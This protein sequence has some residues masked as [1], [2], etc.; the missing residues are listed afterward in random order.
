MVTAGA[1]W[2]AW[3]YI[4]PRVTGDHVFC[5]HINSSR[6]GL[7]AK[8]SLE[9]WFSIKHFPLFICCFCAMGKMNEGEQQFAVTE[10]HQI[11]PHAQRCPPLIF[12][13]SESRCCSTTHP[14]KPHNLT[15][16]CISSNISWQ[17]DRCVTGADAVFVIECHLKFNSVTLNEVEFT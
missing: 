4:T 14:L 9:Y 11:Y 16:C 12:F 3:D 8:P 10:Y 6:F 7:I 15:V 2:Y 5:P 17:E 1:P 13:Y